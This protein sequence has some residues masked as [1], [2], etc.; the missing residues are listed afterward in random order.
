MKEK[1]KWHY[2][3]VQQELALKQAIKGRANTIR[4]LGSC[5][6]RLTS[7]LNDNI[8]EKV[9]STRTEIHSILKQYFHEAFFFFFFS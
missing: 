3:P 7:H 8:E 1:T 2:Q 4:A 5:A 9:Q 6:I